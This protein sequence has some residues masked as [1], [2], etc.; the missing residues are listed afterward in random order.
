MWETP[1]IPFPAVSREQIADIRRLR[2]RVAVERAKKSRF[3]AGRLDH[4]NLDHIHEPEEWAK[5]PILTKDELR[6]IDPA[7]FQD[8]FC[9]APRTEIIEFW[10]SG[11]STGKPLFYPRTMND[12]RLAREGFRRA[13]DAAKKAISPMYLSRSAFTRSDRSIAAPPSRWASA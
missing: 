10:R 12:L 5:I 8:D 11:G 1:E 9:I 2:R 13:W 7:D 6:V 4:L 3:F